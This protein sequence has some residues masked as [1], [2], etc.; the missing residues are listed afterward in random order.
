MY[1]CNHA[2]FSFFLLIKKYLRLYF[3]SKQLIFVPSSHSQ[4]KKIYC[5]NSLVSVR[6]VFKP[7]LSEVLLSK[8]FLENSL[9]L[10]QLN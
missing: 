10:C 6:L 3:N 2:F 1:I 4:K 8:A 7:Y 9:S 5:E